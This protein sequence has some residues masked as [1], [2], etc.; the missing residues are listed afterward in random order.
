MSDVFTKSVLVRKVT[1]QFTHIDSQISETL[2]GEIAR[3]I[4]GKCIDEGYV[5]KNSVSILEYSSGTVA[6]NNVVFRAVVECMIF[7]PAIGLLLDC[8]VKNN[9]SAGIM[10]ESSKKDDKNIPFVL[11]VARD[12]A[13]DDERFNSLKKDD[14]FVAEVQSFRFEINDSEISILGNIK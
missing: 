13:Y 3:D 8:I 7:L 5:K 4:E 12:Y 9:T 6:G 1:L 11:F 2:Q 14:I 10:A